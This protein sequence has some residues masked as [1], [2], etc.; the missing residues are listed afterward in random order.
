MANMSK[1]EILSVLSANRYNKINNK[2]TSSDG[3]KMMM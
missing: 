1:V 2:H 3:A